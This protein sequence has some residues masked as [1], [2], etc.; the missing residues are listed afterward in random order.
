MR[1]RHFIVAAL[2]LVLVVGVSG[3]RP[4]KPIL[5]LLSI[6]GFRWDYADRVQT[7][8]IHRVM[9]HGVRAERMIPAFPTKT[10]PNHYT[11]VT[12]LYPAHHGIVGNSMW[13]Q[14]RQASFG[15]SDRAAV[16]DGRWWGGEPLWVTAQKQGLFSGIM[17]WP[18]SEAAIEG[19]RPRYWKPYVQ[20]VPSNDARVDQLLAWIDLPKSERPAFVTGYFSD[21]DSAGHDFGPDSEEV[22]AAVTRIDNTIGNLLAGLERRDLLDRVNLVLVSDH[23]MAATSPDRVITLSDYLDLKTVKVSDINPTLG[24]FPQAPAT[25][26]DV[27]KKLVGAHPNL[28]VYRREDTP[29]SWHYRDNPRIPPIVGIVDE[30]WTIIEAPPADPKKHPGEGGTHGYDPAYRSMSGIFIAAGPAFRHDGMTVAPFEN[31]HV[32][33]ILAAALQIKPARNDGDPR[34]IESLLS[35]GFAAS[36]R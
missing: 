32:Y 22:R 26:D 33:D 30:G 4:G 2:L 31:I 29:A 36:S 12:G 25:V 24:L 8:N 27:M 35:G 19:V 23:G 20:P 3:C 17:Y 21:V 11:I 5:I 13:D 34:V 1:R 7:P 16:A 9:A 14:E 6:D 28:H 15:M 10:F 18:G